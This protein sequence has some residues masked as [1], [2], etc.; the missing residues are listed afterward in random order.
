MTVILVFWVCLAVPLQAV[1]ESTSSSTPTSSKPSYSLE[2]LPASYA[3]ARGIPGDSQDKQGLAW[4]DDHRVMFTGFSPGRIDSKGLYVWDTVANVVTRYSD[5]TTFCF[6]DGY[7]TAF[8]AVSQRRQDSKASD[9]LRKGR[10]GSEQDVLCNSRLGERCPG[11]L[12][13]SCEASRFFGKWPGGRY[14]TY[15]LELRTADGAIVNP[16]DRSAAANQLRD[17][18]LIEKKAL[19]SQPLLLVNDRFPKGK[20]LPISALEE[21]TAWKATYS[22]YADRYVF[23]TERPKDGFPGYTSIW[24]PGR[25]QPVYL[26]TREGQVEEIDVPPSDNR[27]K[28]HLASIAAPGVV[29]LGTAAPRRGWGGLFLY[30]KHSIW[31][32]D[33]GQTQTLAVSANGC[34]VAYAI[35]SEYDKKP[36]SYLRIKLV[37]FC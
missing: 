33:R 34:K 27:S 26:M 9:L 20:P 5:H 32:L 7:I 31:Q 25:S 8:G 16:I 6:A 1:T 28:I 29:F 3:F 36:L 10:L 14:S 15:V 17:K 21:V 35:D 12:N 2:A 37:T 19:L 4:L 18:N 30:D 22:K 23:V 24:P 11:R 13:M